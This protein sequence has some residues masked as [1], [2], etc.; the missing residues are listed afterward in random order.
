MENNT[1]NKVLYKEELANSEGI[2]SGV[3]LEIVEHEIQPFDPLKLSLFTKPMSASDCIKRIKQG[4]IDLSPDFQRNEVWDKVRRSRLIESL[5]LKIPLPMF[6][7]ASD[8]V[9]NYQVVDGLQRLSTL[10]DF[11]IKNENKKPF[12][13]E[14]LEFWKNYNGYSFDKLPPHLQNRITEAT[15]TFT[16]INPGTPERVKRDVFKRINTGGLTLTDQEIRHALYTGEVTKL[17][18]ALVKSDIFENAT[19]KSIHDERMAGRELI[20]RFISFLIRDPDQYKGYSMDEWLSHTMQIIN[21]FKDGLPEN[22]LFMLLNE[23][24]KIRFEL[25]EIRIKTENEIIDLFYKSMDKAWKLFKE[26][27]FRKSLPGSR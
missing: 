13:L 5:M 1:D 23:G 4:T 12:T 26:Y 25:P 19:N 15:F 24:D 7:V 16:I 3:E 20:L 22:E 21:L 27:A 14:G 6:Y 8:E 10:R 17:L 2:T 11:V 18:N 9:E